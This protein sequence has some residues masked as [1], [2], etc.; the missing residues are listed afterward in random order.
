MFSRNWTIETRKI[1]KTSNQPLSSGAQGQVLP[2]ELV[3][4]ASSTLNGN[5]DDIDVENCE[6]LEN[7][8]ESHA[9]VNQDLEVDVEKE[10]EQ[11]LTES[12]SRSEKIADYSGDSLPGYSSKR[13]KTTST[14]VDHD[15]F[16]KIVRNHPY[17]DAVYRIYKYKQEL[18]TTCQAVLCKVITLHYIKDNLKTPEFE[19]FT[20]K[21]VAL[22]PK[23]IV[24]TYYVPPTRKAVSRTSKSVA[25]KEKLVDKYHNRLAIIRLANNLEK[26]FLQRG[27]E[28]TDIP[29]DCDGDARQMSKALLVHCR[30]KTLVTQH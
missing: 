25:S 6:V 22:F 30:D 5:E 4:I 8:L 24:Q 23:E 18:S 20:N 13:K 26:Q 14:K 1:V 9:L 29:P 17:G 10:I 2:D 16:E 15:D 19:A 11:Q 28:A 12:C 7:V 3:V 21:I 27:A